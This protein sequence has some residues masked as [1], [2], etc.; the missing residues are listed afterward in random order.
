MQEKISEKTFAGQSIYVGI[1]V[2]RKNWKVSILT[3]TLPYKTFSAPPDSDKLDAYLRSHFPGATFY[4]AY[5]AGFSGFWLHRELTRLGIKS[6][7]V[8][9]ADI[10]TTDKER[11]QKEDIRDSR[12]LA[13]TLRAGQLRG[14]YIPGEKTQQDRLL[15][16]VRGTIVRDLTRIKNRIKALLYFQGIV[17]PLQF[18][19]NGSHWSN[20]FIKWLESLPFDHKSGKSALGIYLESVKHKRSLQLRITRQIRELSQSPEYGENVALLTSVPG[21]GVLTAMTLLLELED[22]SRFE[23]FAN[24]CSFVGLVPS[25]HSS[26]DQEINSGITPRK[27][28]RL[29]A[30][31]VESA[32]VAIRNDPALLASYNCLSGRMP[33][34]KAI[35]RIAKKLLRRIVSV[36][37]KKQKYEKGIIG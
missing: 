17:Y 11:K 22:I 29:R 28:S 19:S 26:G 21:I 37:R 13:Q 33:G 15:L 23:N 4:S 20:A 14:I 34:N 30:A 5:E 24:L 6:L 7:V 36:L 31:L 12:K 10:P 18:A 2:H 1:D 9:P 32:W 35:I 3:E 27:N 25:T 8:N 16:R